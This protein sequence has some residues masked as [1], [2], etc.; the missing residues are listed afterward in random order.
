MT[1]PPIFIPQVI[2]IPQ[3]IPV[4]HNTR[5]LSEVEVMIFYLAL[6]ITLLVAGV[7]LIWSAKEDILKGDV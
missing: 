3:F 6:V 2:P 4:H 5:P 7:L 1:P